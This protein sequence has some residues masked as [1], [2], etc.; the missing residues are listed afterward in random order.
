MWGLAECLACTLSLPSFPP[1]DANFCSLGSHVI[2]TYPSA[3]C[4]WKQRGDGIKQPSII[5]RF[6]TSLKIGIVG[7][8]NVGK[9]TFFVV[10]T[11]RL[12]QNTSH[13]ALLILMRA[14]CLCQ[15]RGLIPLPVCHKPANNDPLFP[16]CSRYWWSYKRSSQWAGL[17][18]CLFVPY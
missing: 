1:L 2:L 3:R 8:P 11:N 14:E 10:L 12:Q 6:G 18:Q 15:M 7:L 17:G 13:S 4:P 5:R 9:S 16:K